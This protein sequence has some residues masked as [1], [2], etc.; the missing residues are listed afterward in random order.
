VRY[1]LARNHTT[2]TPARHVVVDTETWPETVPGKPGW[3]LHLFRL[4]HAIA[5]RFEGTRVKARVPLAFNDLS[6]WWEWLRSRMNR[7]EPLIVWAHNLGF[8]LTV[9]RFWERLDAGEYSF[10]GEWQSRAKGGHGRLKTVKWAGFLA[11]EDPPTLCVVRHESGAIVK[12]VDSLNWWRT[13]LRK[14]GAKFGRDKLPFPGWDAGV[15]EWARYCQQDAEIL[16]TAVTHLVRWIRTNDYGVF[17]LTAPAQA[18]AAYKHRFMQHKLIA[19]DWPEVRALERAAYYGGQVELFYRGHVVPR[20]EWTA[21]VSGRKTGSR[22]AA[23][24]GPVYHLDVT[25]LYASV[26]ADQ[27]YP[28][29]LEEVRE[30]V[31][32][33]QVRALLRV[34]C[35]IAWVELGSEVDPWPYRDSTRTEWCIGTFDTK[36]AGAELLRAVEDGHVRRVLRLAL[37]S[38]DRLF[39]DY[40]A[41]FWKKR[42]EAR[43]RGNKIEE[44]LCGLWLKA[45]WGKFGRW[46]APWKD[47]PG[48]IGREPWGIWPR[49]DVVS[50]EVEEYRSIAYHVQLRQERLEDPRAMPSVAACVAAAARERMRELRRIAGPRTVLY[51]ATDSL[52]V[53]Q[54]GYEQLLAAGEVADFQLGKLRVVGVHQRAEYQGLNTYCLDGVWVRAGVKEEALVTAG[55]KLA[56]VDFDSLNTILSRAPQGGVFAR[57]R[58]VSPT[59]DYPRGV[60]AGDGWIA[61]RWIGGNRE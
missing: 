13:S 21:W 58:L 60:I 46:A 53:T 34:Y 12:F 30:D 17:K 40:V 23:L 55:G 59:V 28:K 11:T 31:P 35:G 27:D 1:L 19:H 56:Q 5:L 26:M 33:D 44:E 47:L 25:S 2:R 29:N 22:E 32:L 42:V 10:E 36:L 7:S 9:L 54:A 39:A 18:Y 41:H 6:A 52:H 57:P 20:A 50:G 24:D 4:G 37:Y 45:L 15:W 38:A 3:A 48:E 43:A 14:L 49:L 61:P 16:E 51:Q 8:D